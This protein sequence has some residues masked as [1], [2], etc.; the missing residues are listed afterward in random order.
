MIVK[1][2]FDD[3]KHLA[4]E[5]F[6]EIG[7]SSI[8]ELNIKKDVEYEVY[9][10][11]LFENNIY[12]QIINDANIPEWMPNV[13]FEIINNEMPSDWVCNFFLDDPKLIIGPDFIAKDIN[14]YNAMVELEPNEAKLFW[15]RFEKLK[16]E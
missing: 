3:C 12:L 8:T 14:S 2:K 10:I 4:E 9:A 13:F 15:E 6:K 5:S 1:A 11:S 16:S 7:Y